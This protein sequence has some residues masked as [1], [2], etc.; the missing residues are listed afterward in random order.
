MNLDGD[1][2]EMIKDIHSLVNKLK[3]ENLDL[4]VGW[5]KDQKIIFS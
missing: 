2:L 1:L 5:R 4:V 3:N